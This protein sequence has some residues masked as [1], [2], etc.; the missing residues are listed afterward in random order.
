MRASRAEVQTIDNL[1]LGHTSQN[2]SIDNPRVRRLTGAL[3]SLLQYVVRKADRL[4]V[5]ERHMRAFAAKFTTF[6]EH[7]KL[8]VRLFFTWRF[9]LCMRGVVNNV[10]FTRGSE[11]DAGPKICSFQNRRDPASTP[12]Y[13]SRKA[14]SRCGKG[15]IEI[16]RRQRQRL[17][18]RTTQK[19]CH[20][21]PVGKRQSI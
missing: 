7:F 12:Y 1:L 15:P 17:S 10:K 20:S 18:G 14:W 21:M 8:V 16:P 13:E 11:L 6:I 5:Y 19:G 2:F 4:E 9:A 3:L